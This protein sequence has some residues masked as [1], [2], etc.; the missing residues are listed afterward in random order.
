MALSFRLSKQYYSCFP[1]YKNLLPW[2][3][4]SVGSLLS[5][6]THGKK[7]NPR[8]WEC[9]M[10]LKPSEHHRTI[11]TGGHLKNH[12]APTPLPSAGMLSSRPGCSQLPPACPGALPGMGQ[13]SGRSRTYRK[14]LQS[15]GTSPPIN[16]GIAARGSSS[17][18]ASWQQHF[19]T[20]V[21][22]QGVQRGACQLNFLVTLVCPR[23]LLWKSN[24]LPQLRSSFEL[25]V[26][27]SQITKVNIKSKSFAYNVDEI[28]RIMQRNIWEAKFAW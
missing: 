8:L 25:A 17:Q 12:I 13:N 24:F 26:N 5:W 28:F 2:C 11:W 6:V 9:Q 27:R 20:P 23:V 7:S 4:A 22:K 18:V 15:I 3:F 1:K 10:D 14:A 16:L 21:G 19:V